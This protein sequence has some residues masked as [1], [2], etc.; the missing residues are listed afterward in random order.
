MSSFCCCFEIKNPNEN[1]TLIGNYDRNRMNRDMR[2]LIQSL[3]DLTFE[4]KKLNSFRYN[5][6]RGIFFGVGSAIGASVIAA[7]LIGIFAKFFQSVKNFNF[8]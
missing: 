7:I 1:T 6:F 8:Q 2:N 3:K 4:N 5:F